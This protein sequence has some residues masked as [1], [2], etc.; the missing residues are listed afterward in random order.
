MKKQTVVNLDPID[1]KKKKGFF[2]RLLITR[3]SGGDNVVRSEPYGH[4]MFC[5]SQG[6]GKSVS[7]LWYAQKLVKRYEKRFLKYFDNESKT[8]V[9]FDSVPTVRVFSNMGLGVPFNKREIFQLID[10]FDPYANE[11]RIVIVDEI[12][13]YFP[14][15][16][17]DKET[18]KIQDDLVA[19]FLSS[20]N[21]IPIFFRLLKCM[22][23]L[24]S[25]C[26]NSAYI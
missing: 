21:E 26:V 6:S 13:A 8:F 11:V 10:A 24:K 16:S 14:K 19:I 7:A 15:G 9:K 12:Q 25:P 4:Y 20:E 3:W 1:R 17:V 23:V 18:K 5:G 22:A 2:T